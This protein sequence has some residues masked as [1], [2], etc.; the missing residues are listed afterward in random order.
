MTLFSK[1]I[2]GTVKCAGC[3]KTIMHSE[4]TC[5]CGIENLLRH[6]PIDELE[7]IP[8]ENYDKQVL[9]I[10]ES[11]G[12]KTLETLERISR[13]L[14]ENKLRQ[15]RKN[16]SKRKT[17]TRDEA[18]SIDNDSYPN[19]TVI[20][21]ILFTIIAVFAGDI[22]GLIFGSKT[23]VLQQI[24]LSIGVGFFGL[25]LIL[26]GSFKAVIIRLDKILENSDP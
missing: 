13:T 26:L 3:K 11:N 24:A 20:Y 15:E 10:L 25:G 7:K 8:T 19:G 14:K 18:K 16:Q 6:I 1:A 5:P 23:V 4:K 22:A 9:H 12:V 17:N 2:N 21:G